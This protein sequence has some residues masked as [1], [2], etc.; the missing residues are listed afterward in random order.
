MAKIL[1]AGSQSMCMSNYKKLPKC[2]PKWCLRSSCSIPLS[3]F[4]VVSILILSIIP[5][6]PS[7]KLFETR[8]TRISE[9]YIELITNSSAKEH[10]ILQTF[11]KVKRVPLYFF[12]Q[13]PF[14]I[15]RYK[16]AQKKN[17]EEDT[18]KG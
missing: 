5:L 1:I 4:G 10:I 18:L 8:L 7:E 12:N 6:E 17:V 3:T 11:P 14:F 13:K 2:F 16:V 15:D 9:D